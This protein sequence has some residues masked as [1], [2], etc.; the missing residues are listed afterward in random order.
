MLKAKALQAQIATAQSDDMNGYEDVVS[1]AAKAANISLDAKDK[2]AIEAAVSWKNPEA[3]AVIKKLHKAKADPVY[4]LFEGVGEHAGKTIEYKAD[5]DLR[6]FENV[7]LDPGRSV[8]EVN[9]AYFKKKYNRMYPMHGSMPARRTIKTSK[10]AS[11]VMKFR[12]IA[13]STNINHRAI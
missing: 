10:S 2:K 5:S 7:A 6:D 9:E 13:I 8:N 11:W 4:G 12:S 3:Q 1:K